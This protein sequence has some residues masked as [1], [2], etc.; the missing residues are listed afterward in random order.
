MDLKVLLLS[1]TTFYFL[2][3]C[4]CIHSP[5][6]VEDLTPSTGNVSKASALQRRMSMYSQGTPETPTFKDHSFFVSSVWLCVYA[7]RNLR[8]VQTLQ[9]FHCFSCLSFFF[10]WFQQVTLTNTYKASAFL[11]VNPKRR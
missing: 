8:A 10:P 2:P 6:D 5:F 1:L 7:M 11:A 3:S 4:L 9:T